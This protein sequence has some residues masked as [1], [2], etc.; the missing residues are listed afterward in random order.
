[1]RL[2]IISYH[3]T[4]A[5]A[6]S[7]ERCELL[8]LCQYAIA[9]VQQGQQVWWL[10]STTTADACAADARLVAAA[11]DDLPATCQYAAPCQTYTLAG[12]QL[13]C[14]DQTLWQQPPLRTRLFT[15]LGLLQR[16]LP[17]TVWHA[18]GTVPAPYLTVY[19]ARF[20]GVPAVVSYGQ[21]YLRDGP[22]ER[23]IWH[24]VAQ[25][26]SMALV[27]SA[28]DRERLL[29]TSEVTPAQVRV[30]PPPLPARLHTM[31]A[32]YESLRRPA[33]V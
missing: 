22:Q 24:W 29:A 16:E 19:T 27:S 7:E 11:K 33:R 3:P 20:L 14:V 30:V 21:S 8:A 26:V 18:W 9:L 2:G 23:F 28:A 13:F 15:F 32:L 10:S 5:S 12:M 25:Q 31:I 4:A 1:M 17:G 6:H